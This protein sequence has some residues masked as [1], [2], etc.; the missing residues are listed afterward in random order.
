MSDIVHIVCSVP[1]AYVLGSLKFCLYL[2]PLAVILRYHIM[3]S[4]TTLMQMTLN[5][6]FLLS[7]TSLRQLYLS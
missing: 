5:S 4:A 3:A 2:L 1:Q 6:I 7:V